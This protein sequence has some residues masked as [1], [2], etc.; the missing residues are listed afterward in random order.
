VPTLGYPTR[1]KRKPSDRYIVR[2]RRA[3]RRGKR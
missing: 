2:K 3:G 1:K